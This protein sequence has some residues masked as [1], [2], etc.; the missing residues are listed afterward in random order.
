MMATELRMM[1]WRLPCADCSSDVSQV[2]TEPSARTARSSF[3]SSL[4]D[5][6]IAIIL[7]YSGGR[8]FLYVTVYVRVIRLVTIE[9]DKCRH[10]SH[11]VM[12]VFV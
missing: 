10:I 5:D 6:R 3:I 12:K 9:S 1:P 2:S 7:L 8:I 4:S 11:D